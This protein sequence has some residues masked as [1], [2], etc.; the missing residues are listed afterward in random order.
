MQVLSEFP[1]EG[2]ALPNFAAGAQPTPAG[3][4]IRKKRVG[5]ALNSKWGGSGCLYRGRW[6]T[7][8]QGP[9]GAWRAKSGTVVEGKRDP[10]RVGTESSPDGN[11]E[12]GAWQAPFGRRTSQRRQEV[13]AVA[14]AVSQVGS[15]RNPVGTPCN[16]PGPWDKSLRSG[17][18]RVRCPSSRSGGRDCRG[19]CRRSLLRSG[20][21]FADPLP[22]LGW[23]ETSRPGT[24]SGQGCPG[25]H[26]LGLPCKRPSG[27]GPY[28]RSRLSVGQSLPR[29]VGSPSE[30]AA[31]RF[32]SPMNSAR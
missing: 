21:S 28:V 29:A 18:Y 10:V 6:R 13:T 16:R 11:Q 2:D 25:D 9:G 8:R 5:Q 15:G 17:T 23:L 14:A 27:G 22:P 30:R 26:C 4:K 32:T 3:S 1:G 19:S 7:W 31:A 24:G 20:G 12:F